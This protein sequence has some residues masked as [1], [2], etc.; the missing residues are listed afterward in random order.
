[1]VLIIIIIQFLIL[2]GGECLVK[3]F[4][5]SPVD[6][7]IIL[8]SRIAGDYRCLSRHSVK[9]FWYRPGP[10]HIIS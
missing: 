4:I 7:Y 6:I 2:A 10:G 1:M 9:I 8:Y 3:F 5:Q